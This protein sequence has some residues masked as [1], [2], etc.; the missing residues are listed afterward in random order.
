MA[1][2]HRRT[3]GAPQRAA[4]TAAALLTA[5]LVPVASSGAQESTPET[6][7]IRNGTAKA[8]A[9]VSRIGPGVGDLELAMRGGLAITQLTNSLA[10]ATSQ[11]LDL[12][13]I[14]SSLTAEGCNG[15]ALT[16]EDL[17]QPTFVD[18]RDGDASLARDESGG[19]GDAP[20]GL[21]RM[22]VDATD[23]PVGA[24]AATSTTAAEVGQGLRLTGGRATART[25]VLPGKG[26]EA[27]AEVVSTLELG[28]VLSLEGMRWRAYHR[29]GV[30]PEAEAGFEIGRASVGGVPMPTSDTEAFEKAAN[31]ALAPFGVRIL[32]PEV[33]R[34]L[35]PTD[36]VRVS[37][38]RIEI[39]DSPL[40]GTL[41]GPL[42][43]ATREA[44]GD[45]F[46]SLTE[47]V[48]EAS[49]ILLV[50]DIALSVISGTGFLTID[51][52]GAEASSS[53]FELKSPFGEI[54]PVPPP[55]PPAVAPSTGGGSSA[56]VAAPPVVP[57]PVTAPEAT[58]TGPAVPASSSRGPFEEL[59]E[60]IN[61]NGGGCSEGAA[62]TVGLLALLAT[63]GVAGADVLRQ[64]RAGT[65]GDA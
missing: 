38:L 18:N 25:E 21:G 40:G 59:C 10:Q 15:A 65:G 46:D 60:S 3:V 22:Q 26:R 45:L 16:P 58:T 14:G 28:G 55:A 42:L 39:R 63:V 34:L 51:L 11:T 48:C 20:F 54:G 61:P 30:E 33:Q 17:P 2:R 43:G 52:G 56:P 6:G 23:E 1:V 64:R 35:E 4:L 24:R 37:G 13:L 49:S 41:F 7:E 36:L 31:D 32:L 44:R 62:A 9:M 57:Q 8:V 12:G 53:D 50:G 19:G 27:L 29:T 5:L 47:A